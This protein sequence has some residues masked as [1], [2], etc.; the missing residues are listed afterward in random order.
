MPKSPIR[1][2]I[3]GMGG[4]AARHHEALLQLENAGEARLVCTCD[5]APASFAA[6]A[7]EWKLADRGVALHGDYRKML[8]RHAAELDVVTVPTPIPLHAEM[9]RAIVERGLAVYLEKPPT[10]DPR[11]LEQMIATDAKAKVP[12]LVGFNFITEAPRQAIKRRLVQGEFGRLR[13]AR[14]LGLWPRPTAYF[15]RNGWAGRLVGDDGRL[16]L[17]SCVG[18]ALSHHVHNLLHWAGVGAQDR[19]ASP[20]KV[21]ANLL[22]AHDI[23]GADTFFLSVD[24]DSGV[25]IRIAL[26]HACIGPHIHRETLVCDHATIDYITNDRADIRWRDGGVETVKLGEFDAQVENFRAFFACFRSGAARPPTTLP[27]SRPFVHLHALSYIAADHIQRF[28]A[29]Q[30]A[31]VTG[32]DSHATFVPV[33]GINEAAERFLED[34][35]WPW[36]KPGSATPA[37]L[38]QLDAV[39]RRLAA[40]R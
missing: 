37:Q 15:G 11:E 13:E 30:V 22:R 20:T 29:D 16:I 5:P 33:R 10:L 32:D 4:Y 19:W 12:T 28:P 17:D 34:G 39:V 18:N 25:P 14:L 24:T 38:D 1:V 26:S 35:T 8:D 36:G 23:Q 6:K 27:D 21:R 31:K 9:H 40:E 3:I 7:A 2:G